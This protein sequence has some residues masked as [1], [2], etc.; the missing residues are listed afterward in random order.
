MTSDP[1]ASSDERPRTSLADSP[2]FWF[3][4]FGLMALAALVVVGPKFAARQSKLQQNYEGRRDAW[5]RSVTNEPVPDAQPAP[6]RA[7]STER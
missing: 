7:G 5:Q 2:W 4:L 3:A 1:L 6:D